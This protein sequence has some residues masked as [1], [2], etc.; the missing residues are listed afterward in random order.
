MSEQTSQDK[1]PLRLSFCGA[2]RSRVANLACAMLLW[3]CLP[4]KTDTSRTRAFTDYGGSEKCGEA[5]ESPPPPSPTMQISAQVGTTGASLLTLSQNCSDPSAPTLLQAIPAGTAVQ[6]W[7]D[8]GTYLKVSI[9]THCGC[10]NKQALQIAIA[11]A[12]QNAIH[13][14][15]GN[16]KAAAS[17][18]ANSGVNSGTNSGVVVGTNT[19]VNSTA[20]CPQGEAM[21]T[22]T[23]NKVQCWKDTN[24][25]YSEGQDVGIPKVTV[26]D[27]AAVGG[28]EGKPVCMSPAQKVRKEWGVCWLTGSCVTQ[29]MRHSSQH[30]CWIWEG[31]TK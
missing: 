31:D 12:P 14:N 9:G 20:Q 25:K 3:S 30:S 15:A 4:A 21:L 7:G 10:M 24:E 27:D 1:P 23:N 6:A 22:L 29:M 17:T 28:K 5:D 19:G 26:P 16:P 11:G 2:T 8:Y 18:G 13:P